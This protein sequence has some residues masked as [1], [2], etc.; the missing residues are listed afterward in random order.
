MS[1][2]ALRLAATR[3]KNSRKCCSKPARCNAR[4][5]LSRGYSQVLR[6]SKFYEI[7][8]FFRLAGAGGDGRLYVHRLAVASKEERATQIDARFVA[9]AQHHVVFG[10]FMLGR[11]RLPQNAAGL[12]HHRF[13]FARHRFRRVHF[14]SILEVSRRE[15][16]AATHENKRKNDQRENLKNHRQLINRHF[17]QHQ[18]EPQK[19]RESTE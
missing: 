7:S 14:V 6:Q 17:R 11:L 2:A 9:G 3:R 1:A 18:N 13:Q 19:R 8:G 12:V 10:V 5:N 16:I 15:I 4:C